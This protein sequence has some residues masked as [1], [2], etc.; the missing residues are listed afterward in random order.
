MNFE[1]HQMF[2]AILMAVLAMSSL[3]LGAMIGVYAKPSRRVTAIVMAFGTG[4]LI[5]ALA[6]ELAFEG[7]ERLKHVA[8]LGGL[9]SWAWVAVGF[10]AG[11]MLYYLGNRQ[12]E[13]YGA[14]LR[15]PALTKRFLLAKKREKSAALLAHLAKVDL[16]RALPPEEMDE[17]VVCAEPAHFE[18]G[19]TIFRRGD[20]GD[21]LYMIVRGSV[22]VRANGDGAEPL[23]RLAAGQSFGEMALLNDEKRTAT[24]VAMTD[25]EVLKIEKE[26]FNE[27]LDAS[28]RLRRAVEALNAQ[29]ILEN[30][31]ARQPAAE[32]ADWKKLALANI[33]RLNRHEEASLMEQHA[34]SGAPL[35]L[36]LGALLDGIPES[37]VI[38]SAF[39]GLSSFR[40]TFLAAVFV[41]NLPEAMSSAVSMLHAGFSPRRIFGLWG[42]LIVAGA[43]A[44]AIGSVFLAG[45]SPIAV[46]LVG[47]IAG[48]G[49]LAMVSSVM[50]PEAYENGG[51]A[52]GLATIAGFL[53]ALLFTFI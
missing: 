3:I 38:G 19:E 5:H 41:A 31:A 27:L 16:L 4:A 15:H 7:A 17:V 36:F 53:T 26:P 14:A 25:V 21:A 44:A 1:L 52:V 13:Q 2:G 9:T 32:E 35:A 46:S 30:V 23:A 49:I 34:S 20:E 6:L 39:D 51:P 22:E 37:L 47:A 28:P 12:L 10:A 33:R 8:H 42:L 29:R 40:F 50:M 48:G 11:G 45:A 43:I 18:A 24:V